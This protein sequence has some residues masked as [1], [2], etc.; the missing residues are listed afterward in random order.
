MKGWLLTKENKQNYGMLYKSFWDDFLQSFLTYPCVARPAFLAVARQHPAGGR[1][2]LLAG[3]GPGGP[4]LPHQA[5][6][7]PPT[8]R[9]RLPR[10]YRGRRGGPVPELCPVD[11]RVHGRAGPAAAPKAQRVRCHGRGR[12]LG[13]GGGGRI[14]G[15]PSGPGP[16]S[17]ASIILSS[18]PQYQGP[19]VVF[20]QLINQNTTHSSFNQTRHI[21]SEYI[22]K[23]SAFLS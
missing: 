2:G 11:R 21:V 5:V 20:R 23:S 17:S 3:P 7:H 13:A 6:L 15:L 9:R 14:S 19:V 10:R 1:R 12:I 4:L 18:H 16:V 22:R 8:R